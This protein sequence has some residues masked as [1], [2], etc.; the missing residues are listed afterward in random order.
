MARHLI[1]FAF[2]TVL[3]IIVTAHPTLDQRDAAPSPENREEPIPSIFV[4]GLERD[5][6]L[7]TD[8][9]DPIQLS[10]LVLNTIKDMS[11]YA[12]VAD[13]PVVNIKS[14]DVPGVAI[15]I[16]LAGGM[17]RLQTRIQMWA[18]QLCLQTLA[19][20][21]NM[22]MISP[23]CRFGYNDG[24]PIRPGERPRWTRV[25]GH[26]VFLKTT[27][28]EDQIS[29]DVLNFD[30][31][32]ELEY[33]PYL[34]STVETSIGEDD[35]PS[36]LKYELVREDEMDEKNKDGEVNTPAKY[37]SSLSPPLNED[38]VPA[39]YACSAVSFVIV[40]M[41]S[42]T[43]PRDQDIDRGRTVRIRY[44]EGSVA[45]K[46]QAHDK[47]EKAQSYEAWIKGLVSVIWKIR[48]KKEWKSYNFAIWRVAD[49]K[50]I[51]DGS[52]QGYGLGKGTK[53]ESHSNR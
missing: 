43:R 48:Y 28:E 33:W 12:Y 34:N 20:I 10:W 35:P 11:E 52:V 27:S 30:E 18:L 32:A 29:P 50:N 22:Q 19:P 44:E 45:L 51:I 46:Y 24:P 15:G 53:D 39:A 31:N 38:L 16:R 49:E 9:P 1:R 2:V 26:V 14:K 47:N 13:I 37:T 5:S 6:P 42:D 21:I 41:A 8:T 17:D 4:V 7:T 3:S 23:R 25:L 36:D 40:A